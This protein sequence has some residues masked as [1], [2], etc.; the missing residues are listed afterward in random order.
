MARGKFDEKIVKFVNQKNY[1]C[2]SV[3]YFLMATEFVSYLGFQGLITL[4]QKIMDRFKLQKIK[5]CVDTYHFNT[6]IFNQY[7]PFKLKKKL[8]ITKKRYLFDWT[9]KNVRHFCLEVSMYFN[10]TSIVPCGQFH[11]HF[12]SAFAPIFLR[13]KSF[14]LKCKYKKAW[15]K[16]FA[17]KRRA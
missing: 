2:I 3:W 13:Q 5:R 10:C 9:S 7:C 17:Q 15:R 16:T 11:Q 4:N 6:V 8:D 14:N 12:M 1:K